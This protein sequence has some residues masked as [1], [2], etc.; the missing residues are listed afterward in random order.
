MNQ[1]DDNPERVAPPGE[2]PSDWALEAFYNKQLQREFYADLDP[3]DIESRYSALA[4]N[5]IH[6]DSDILGYMGSVE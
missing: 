4:D 6:D 3:D 5:H 1:P 2:A